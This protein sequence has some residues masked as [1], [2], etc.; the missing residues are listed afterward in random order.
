[1][2]S[3]NADNLTGTPSSG[4]ASGPVHRDAGPFEEGINKETELVALMAK[5]SLVDR[6]FH[7]PAKVVISGPL[8][9][10]TTV[11]AEE[12]F[13]WSSPLSRDTRDVQSM[14]LQHLAH[15]VFERF[16]IIPSYFVTYPILNQEDGYRPLV[17]YLQDGKCEIAAQLHPWVNPPFEES[18]HAENSFAGNLPLR[19]EYNKIRTLTEAIT[20]RFGV[21]PQSYRAGRYGVGPRTAAILQRFGYRVDSS[22]VPEHTYTHERGP[23][24]FDFPPVPYWVDRG[25]T[26]LEL[27]I[28]SGYVG[29][30]AERNKRLARA[31]SMMPERFGLARSLAARTGFVERIRLTPEGTTFADARRLVHALSQRGTKVFT[32][33]YHTP[34]LVPGA[35]PYVRT[36]TDRDRLLDWL[37]RFYEF[38]FGEMGGQPATVMDILERAKR[39]RSGMV[40]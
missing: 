33:S 6:S 40:K 7:S 39:N 36:V 14:R 15:R 35:T 16:G 1:M 26:L 23:E 5:T 18:I 31:I 9:L 22:V 2:A 38:F 28:S 10:A 17:E 13:D 27:P 37:E 12:S 3:N 11:D 20:K 30:I 19:L 25:Q 8:L 4:V 32:L 34:S 21:R 24:F 29:L